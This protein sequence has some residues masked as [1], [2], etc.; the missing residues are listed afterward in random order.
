ML[1]QPGNSLSTDEISLR[2]NVQAAKGEGKQSPAGTGLCMRTAG[3]SVHTALVCLSV[4]VSL[5]EVHLLTFVSMEYFFV[6]LMSTLYH[7][8]STSFINIYA[9]N[10]SET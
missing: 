7:A 4:S 3:L 5:P 2:C 9:I 8:V 1:N 6:F 10:H